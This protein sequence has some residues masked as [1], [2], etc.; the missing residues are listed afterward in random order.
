MDGVPHLSPHDL[1]VDLEEAYRAKRHHHMFAFFGTGDEQ[2]LTFESGVVKVVPVRSEIELREKL[3]ALTADDGERIA[4]LVPWTH[5]V[6]LDIAGRFAL[7][8]R[9]RRIGKDARLRA[10]FGVA[11]IDDDARRSP[12]ADYLL[13]P[14]NA[15]RYPVSEARLTLDALWSVWLRVDWNVET[16]GGLALDTLLAFAA[17]DPHGP[18]FVQALQDPAAAGTREALLAWMESRAA[19]GVTAVA[20]WRAWEQGEGRRALQYAL[21]CEPLARNPLGHVRMWLKTKLR[22]ALKLENEGDVLP[23]ANALARE[24]ASAMRILERR[25][26]V[27][28][29]RVLAREADELVDDAE[30]RAELA[31]S[32]RLPSAW[33]LRLARLGAALELGVNALTPEAAQEATRA[34]R[35]LETHAFFKDPD[36]A[37]RLKRAEMAVRLLCF[38]VARPD[39][40]AHP[41]HTP[42]GE[43]E[44]LGRWYAEE[45][46]YVDRA[47]R[48]ARGN[49]DDAFGK[50]VSAVVLR[51]D[52]VRGVLD[53]VFA[54]SLA[55][56]VEAG[57]PATQ[58]LPIHDA[59]K[60]I[61]ARFLEGN[62]DR[63]LLVLLLDGMAWAQ[64]V[65]LL[66]SVGSRAAPWGPLA[67]H[68]AKETRI[69]EGSLPVVFAAIP[70]VTEVSRSSFFAGKLFGPGAKLT[71]PDPD[72]WA[73]N[74]SV[75]K[76]VPSTDVPRLLLRGEGHTKAG[77]A[78]TEAIT[79]VADP[80]RRVVALVLNAIDDSLKAS[81][82]VRHPWGVENIASLPDLLDKAREHGRAILLASDHGHIPADRIRRVSPDSPALGARWRAWTAPDAP[83]LENEVGFTGPRVY[84]PPGAHGVVL[85]ADDASAYTGSTH[86]GEHGGASLAEVVAPCL[87][88]GCADTLDPTRND[89]GLEVRAARVPRWWHFDVEDSVHAEEAPAPVI[90]K[91]KKPEAQM[92]LQLGLTSV[93]PEPARPPPPTPLAPRSAFITSEVLKARVKGAAERQGVADAVDLLLS[94][95]GVMSGDAFAAA[96]RVLPF[97]VGGLI[98]KLQ[99]VLNLDGYEVIRFDPAARQ[100]HLDRNKL[101]QLFEVTL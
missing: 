82:A 87:L 84:T 52:D 65:E 40:R 67:W 81:H 100:V 27:P 3:P 53:R 76:L 64:A 44:A 33:A 43:A 86:A 74:A 14:T 55:K 85:L 57:Q 35:A 24:A 25:M 92:P 61:A 99:E 12:L 5:D 31:E 83:L 98:S 34:L 15:A 91:P 94:R 7:N 78:S 59:V 58:A 29:L 1:R 60:R 9:V 16:E 21:L 75:K 23:V 42:Y 8:G 95:Q 10:L 41:G 90:V 11:E 19:L 30:V 2:V 48:A 97:R 45:G 66:E 70:T 4:F 72:H 96:M 50:G 51:A 18:R 13:R 38:L 68:S 46:G 88:I 20:T 17:A 28:E 56:W 37:D 39:K 36:E 71:T 47:R 79:L 73:A 6:P 62:E 49:D 63:R 54:N 26:A 32:V 77:G 89:P 22:Q 69:G 93:A 80:E 101:A